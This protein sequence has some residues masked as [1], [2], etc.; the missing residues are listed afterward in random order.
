MVPR[1]KPSGAG[2]EQGS[3]TDVELAWLAGILDGEGW[4]GVNRATRKTTGKHRYSAGCVVAT[5]SPRLANRIHELLIRLG[6]SH[7]FI[8]VPPKTGKDGSVRRR[9]WNISIAGN[10]QTGVLLPAVLPYLVEKAAQANLTLEYIAR[11]GE[12]PHRPG[13][14]NLAVNEKI[15]ALGEKYRSLL[16][17]D[18]NRDDPS[19]TTRL[20]PSG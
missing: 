15:R 5:T 6:V 2:N 7:F 3:P 17:A 4:I 14:H 18:R 12:L 8:E 9:K 11:R 13:G 10:T 1:E 19:T 16:G 20:A